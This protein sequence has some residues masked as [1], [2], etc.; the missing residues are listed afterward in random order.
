MNLK[1]FTNSMI[2]QDEGHSGNEKTGRKEQFGPFVE[3][4]FLLLLE[5]A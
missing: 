5:N 3:S 1:A 2:T 4:E